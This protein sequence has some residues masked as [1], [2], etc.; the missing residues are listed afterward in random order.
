MVF[1]RNSGAKIKKA[2]NSGTNKVFNL[3]PFVG[4]LWLFLCIHPVYLGVPYAY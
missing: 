1:S 2:E 4:W 3:F